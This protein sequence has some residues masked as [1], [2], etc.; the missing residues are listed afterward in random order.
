M[1]SFRQILLTLSSAAVVAAG[2]ETASPRRPVSNARAPIQSNFC[3]ANNAEGVALPSPGSPRSGAPWEK[4]SASVSPVV[5][6]SHEESPDVLK[7]N[8]DEQLAADVTNRDRLTLDELVAEVHERN[9]SLQA[10]YAAWEAA[11]QKYPQVIALDDPTLMYMVAPQ[12]YASS[13]PTPNSWAIQVSQK[14]PGPGKRGWRGEMAA[15]ESHAAGWDAETTQRQLTAATKLAYFDFVLVYEQLRLNNASLKLLQEVHD[16]A[17]AKFENSLAPQQD[18][19]QAEVELSGRKLREVELEQMRRVAAGRINTLLHRPV[20]AALPPPAKQDDDR[21]D[22]PPVD[23]LTRIALEQHPD[24]A[25]KAARLASEQAAV[26]LA[27]K[28][29]WP[30]VELFVRHDTFWFDREQRT[31]LGFSLN[32]P[33]QRERRRA[34]VSEAV[35]RVNQKCHELQSQTDQVRFEVQSAVAKLNESQQSLEIYRQQILD[36]AERNVSAARAAYEA[37]TAGLLPLVEAQ[38][39]LIDFREKEAAAAAESHRRW[40]ELERVVGN[41]QVAH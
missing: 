28:E 33:V 40:A 39:Q 12:S 37:N 20:D 3:E 10:M 11:S 23:D 34:A 17:K 31:S 29:F 5:A 32:L 19:L 27:A 26:E 35:A 7:S 15:W 18:L 21:I 24:L 36:S 1:F 8:A 4:S 13:S 41:L 22:L 38:R 25:A 2:C 30:D 16:L 6:A 14:F 9:P